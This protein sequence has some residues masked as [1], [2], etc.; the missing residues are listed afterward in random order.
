MISLV[1]WRGKSQTRQWLAHRPRFMDDSEARHRRMRETSSSWMIKWTELDCTSKTHS[2]VRPNSR[3]S[4]V[5]GFHW[6]IAPLLMAFDVERQGQ[7]AGGLIVSACLWCEKSGFWVD[8]SAHRHGGCHTLKGFLLSHVP[9]IAHL[10]LL[11]Q[12]T[13]SIFTIWPTPSRDTPFRFLKSG[14]NDYN[15]FLGH[16]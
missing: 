2:G 16:C 12:P 10:T 7:P 15:Q 13:W 9:T 4:N 5:L 1:W 8:E 6:Y 11:T 14:W 3:S